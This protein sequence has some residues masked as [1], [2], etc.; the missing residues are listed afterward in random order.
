MNRATPTRRKGSLVFGND[1]VEYFASIEIELPIKIMRWANL[2]CNTLSALKLDVLQPLLKSDKTALTATIKRHN[3]RRHCIFLSYKNCPPVLKLRICVSVKDP[4]VPLGQT[5]YLLMCV[6]SEHQQ[7]HMPSIMSSSK[8]SSMGQNPGGIKVVISRPY[9]R[10]KDRFPIR[11]LIGGFSWPIVLERRSTHGP[12][13][14]CYLPCR[15]D[16]LLANWV[17]YHHSRQQLEST[18]LGSIAG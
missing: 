13:A 16:A 15:H 8:A 6:G 1:F 4:T 14:D 18:P 2:C 12:G 3:C 17:V 5:D 11:K 10:G 9:G 7:F